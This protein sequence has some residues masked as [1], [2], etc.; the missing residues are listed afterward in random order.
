MISRIFSF[1]ISRQVF[2][3]TSCSDSNMRKKAVPENNRIFLLID[4]FL[5]LHKDPFNA[6]GQQE[7]QKNGD[8]RSAVVIPLNA[9]G[10]NKANTAGTDHTQNRT[11]REVDL[12]THT[13]PCHDLRQGRRQYR[14]HEYTQT[15]HPRCFQGFQ[16]FR[17]NAFEA[18]GKGFCKEGCCMHTQACD[19]RRSP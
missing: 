3:K 8:P 5:D 2:R 17:R 9:V 16:R 11:F 14:I 1:Y 12:K 18:L 10:D 4:F 6:V 19:P 15:G 7:H 13:C